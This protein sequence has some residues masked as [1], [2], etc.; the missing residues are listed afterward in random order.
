MAQTGKI[1]KVV[2]EAWKIVLMHDSAIAGPRMKTIVTKQVFIQTDTTY[3][4]FSL[5][6]WNE[7]HTIEGYSTGWPLDL[8]HQKF[9]YWVVG[10]ILL[11]SSCV[12]DLLHAGKCIASGLS[13]LTRCCTEPYNSL[14]GFLISFSHFQLVLLGIL[15]SLNTLHLSARQRA[16]YPEHWYGVTSL[17]S[18]NMGNF[19][20]FSPQGADLGP[21]RLMDEV[22]GGTVPAFLIPLLTSAA[23]IKSV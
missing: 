21:G 10:G 11:T 9:V 12:S 8:C 17:N 1:S 7:L 2:I 13:L 19:K 18:N 23:I 15:D 16:G 5:D 20:W 22:W 4:H 6:N 3:T 14:P